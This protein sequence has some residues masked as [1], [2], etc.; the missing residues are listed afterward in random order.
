MLIVKLRFYLMILLFPFALI[1]PAF[2][3][4]RLTIIDQ[5]HTPL[6]NAV[7]EY[8]PSVSLTKKTTDAEKTYIMD[9]IDKQFAPHVLII[10][11][12]SL[13]SFPNSD[14]VRHHVYSFSTAKTFELKLYAGKPKSPISFSKIGVVVMGCNIHDSMVGYIYVTANENTVLSNEKGEV[15]IAPNLPL[16]SQ[17][18]VWHPNNSKG[19]SK[20]TIFTIDPSM[21]NSKDEITL[22][23]TVNEPA[24]RDSFEEF[25][26]HE[27]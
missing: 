9:Q 17:I 3:Q 25:T 12:D 16:Q 8:S 20:H 4:M 10:P 14:D 6:P 1:E 19:V 26:V 5:N 18:Q 23:I 2:S 7:I 22:M 15:L 11:V 21:I 27:H 24:P 13:V